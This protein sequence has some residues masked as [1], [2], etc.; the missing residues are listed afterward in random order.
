MKDSPTG[1]CA[2]AL[3]A[4][5]SAVV[6]TAAAVIAL[7]MA[8]CGTKNRDSA[9]NSAEPTTE[10]APQPTMTPSTVATTAALTTG[11]TT[12]G[13]PTTAAPTTKAPTTE[14]PSTQ[15]PTTAPATTGPDPD[16]RSSENPFGDN[17][18]LAPL[19]DPLPGRP[20]WYGKRPLSV[21]ADGIGAAQTTPPELENRSFPTIDRLPPPITADFYSD[22]RPIPDEILARSTWREDCP[23][24]R[25]EL[26]YVRVSHWGFEGGVHTG[27]MILNAEV[28]EDVVSVFRRLFEI[29]Y[30]IESLRVADME[31]LDTTIPPTGDGNGSGAFVCRAAK[32]STRWS[33]HAYGTAIDLNSF[34]NPY[35]KDSSV[36]PELATSYLD[37]DNWRPGM[38]RADGQVVAAF[39]SIG[40]GWGGSW[41][42]SKDYMHFS[43]SGR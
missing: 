34:Q 5:A 11:A 36:I 42:S 6:L 8:G 1:M 31:A 20:D 35:K 3:D 38:I 30:P 22:I 33:D 24:T 13:P 37:R 28:A 14:A 12:T 17:L 32:K 26:R 25:D 39:A 21:D 2:R 15:V 10:P 29:E 27:E 16:G 4:R 9:V 19:P 18:A 43:Q 40:W 7:G 41:R 23:V